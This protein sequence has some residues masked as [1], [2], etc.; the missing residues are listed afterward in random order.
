MPVLVIGMSELSSIV[1]NT[2]VWPLMFPDG[3]VKYMPEEM[4]FWDINGCQAQK[5]IKILAEYQNF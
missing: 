3:S 4:F 5:I 1:S 2:M